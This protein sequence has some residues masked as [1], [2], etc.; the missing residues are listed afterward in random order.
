[1]PLTVPEVLDAGT[2]VQKARLGERT[3]HVDF[4][5]H[6]GVSPDKL[7]SLEGMW[8]EGCTAFK[9]FTCETHCPMA[10]VID[11]ADLVE[12]LTIIARLRGL[13]TFHAENNELLVANLARLRAEGRADNGA[14]LAWRTET[15]EL[16][17]INRILFYAERTGARVNIVHVTSP[18]G[19][20][21]IRRARERGVDA[22]A[23]TCPHYLYLTEDDILDRGAW[24]T[25]AP[26]M[27]SRAARD[28]MIA[29]VDFGDI[30]T[31]GSDHG[32]VDPEL[33]RR[34]SNNILDGQPG[35]PGNETM[36]PLMLDLAARGVTS[37]ERVA[38]VCS[39]APA[40]LYG[41]YPRKGAIEIGSDADFTVV[42]PERA[43]TI[44]QDVLIGKTGWT[45]Y[46]GLDVR[47]RVAMTIIRG[48]VVAR[49]GRVVSRPG[50]AAFVPRLS[51]LGAAPMSA[52]ADARWQQPGA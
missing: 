14:F 29:L 21:L 13:A 48:R 27:R 34:G 41:L 46:E 35:M 11:D 47:G 19:V 26:P 3:S 7:A 50:H 40:R 42:D 28:G 9:I 4:A 36:V 33:K 8:L 20:A 32:P 15:L 12:A 43:W 23:E 51:S 18:D 24:V 38:E 16:E 6:G 39:E 2:L 31:V 22:T 49:D 37:L 1:M 5:L 52:P 30:L 45:P 17:A 10:G 44:R 25:C